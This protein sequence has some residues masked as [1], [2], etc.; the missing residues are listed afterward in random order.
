M[1]DP[2]PEREPSQPPHRPAHPPALNVP[3]IVL[4]FGAA[5]VLVHLYATYALDPRGQIDLL[6]R[7]AFVP[8]FMDAAADLLRYPN[9]RWWSPLTYGFLH[10]DWTHLLV[11]SV[12]LLAFGTP[13]AK[14][15]G[16]GRFV[17]FTLL[18]FVA[19]AAA[20]YVMHRGELVPVVGASGAVSAYFGAAARFAL[21]PGRLGSDAALMRP[22]LSLVQTLT[23]RSTLIFI[24][25]WLAI[26]WVA[27]SGVVPIGQGEAQIAWEA[28]VGGF[29]LG[30]LA[31][32]FFDP[33]PR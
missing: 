25:I 4:L 21:L 12:W 29:L 19:G 5:F 28:H 1:S 22:A 10:G 2:Q 16:A 23:T 32:R 7:F 13:V 11:N 17:V 30:L 26:N 9:A 27:G 31:F 3:T 14:R 15:F 8:G 6:E 33:L 18:A 20:H 24:V